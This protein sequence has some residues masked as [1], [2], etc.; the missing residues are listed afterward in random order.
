MV[1]PKK[2]NW[3]QATL[4]AVTIYSTS[5]ALVTTPI[6][7]Q[8]APQQQQE[9][10][11]IPGI[12][13]GVTQQITGAIVQQRQQMAQMQQ[14]IQM[15]NSLAPKTVPAKF[16]PNCVVP[17]SGSATPAGV[18]ESVDPSA[19]GMIQSFIRLADTYEAHYSQ[20]LS[21]AQHSQFPAGLQCIDGERKKMMSG[22]QR[23]QN[24]LQT[25][26]A[27]LKKEAQ[28]FR[29]RNKLRLEAMDKTYAELHGLEGGAERED[30]SN[31][32]LSRDYANYFS[33]AC[34]NV[35]GRETLNNGVSGGL[36]GIRR[37]FTPLR[38]QAAKYSAD[39]VNM[40]QDFER[41]MARIS[42]S[43]NKDGI[44]FFSADP[45]DLMI[46]N[47]EVTAITSEYKK[48]QDEFRRLQSSVQSEIT[49]ILGPNAITL[50]SLR[51]DAS[52]QISRSIANAEDFF[53]KKDIYECV[54]GNK[55]GLALSSEQILNGLKHGGDNTHGNVHVLYRQAL[56]NILNSSSSF[57][58]KI[59]E[60]RQLD[61]EY[62]NEVTV[63][64][65]DEK[66]QTV[67]ETPYSLYQKTI[68][69]CEQAYNQDTTFQADQQN[70]D[71]TNRSKSQDVQR[72]K[73]LLADYK[74]KIDA[75]PSVIQNAITDRVLNCKGRSL[76]SDSC[77]QGSLYDVSGE[78]FCFP[79]ADTCKAQVNNCFIEA[80]AIVQR[81]TGQI[82]AEA[83]LFN[84]EAEALIATQEGI[85]KQISQA[86]I[87][88]A[89]FLSQYFSGAD[90]V[91]PADLFV[92][93]PE[94]ALK[95]GELLR[96]GGEINFDDLISKVESLQAQLATQADG[97]NNEINEYMFEV[98]GAI[99]ENKT[100]WA[101]IRGKCNGAQQA[102]ARAVSEANQAQAAA[103]GEQDS[104]LGDFCE[105]FEGLVGTNNPGAGCSGPYSA[106]KLA[107]EMGQ[108]VR[109]LDPNT[110]Y[111]VQQYNNIC[112]QVQN[113]REEGTEDTDTVD[114]P[115][116]DYIALCRANPNNDAP[117]RRSFIRDIA[118]VDNIPTQFRSQRSDIIKYLS[119][120]D[121]TLPAALIDS[122]FGDDLAIWRQRLNPTDAQLL[123]G[124]ITD[125]QLERVDSIANVDNR[126]CRAL[127]ISAAQRANPDSWDTEFQRNLRSTNTE[128]NE[129]IRSPASVASNEVSDLSREWQNIGENARNRCRA[130]HQAN[131]NP[132]GGLGG[133]GGGLPM[134]SAADF[135]NLGLGGRTQ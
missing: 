134:P 69:R 55:Y 115:N 94:L 135:Q 80:D 130:Q 63:T 22:M 35:I 31:E 33:P 8:Q 106:Q 73:R 131:R 43:L 89:E 30:P 113:E 25:L 27:Q 128:L 118:A 75:F 107:T 78:N 88:D 62:Q 129:S 93:M 61:I 58:Q 32:A 57:D 81:K 42:S 36:L 76:S 117:V 50:P 51:S 21:K 56:E 104:A 40:R 45:S 86:V 123:R 92:A 23:R 102:V 132:F 97:I 98:Q 17:E 72:V 74:N 24:S 14:Q 37:D 16:F 2:T 67:T 108:V 11:S 44:D 26:I 114:R 77:S 15:M 111:A 122:A 6:Y 9:E 12:L 60:I 20:M 99:Q 28:A 109:S 79:H 34:H 90:F 64:Y 4:K 116:R 10:M 126:V 47:M 105:R 7:S 110:R 95:N 29:D 71:T 38:D 91:Y 100:K 85:L 66:A 3:K 48:Q 127:A 54:T 52:Q 112:N 84:E 5:F 53:R 68:A 83:K 103:Q 96:G 87:A 1:N 121:V 18:C 39:S 120:E 65:R 125:E 13:I 119:G 124:T 70:L 41:V 19:L 82:K 49:E 101:G 46:G 59:I 133:F